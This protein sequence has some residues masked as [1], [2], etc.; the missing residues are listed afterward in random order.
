MKTKIFLLFLALGMGTMQME[1][2]G[3]F[4]QLKKAAKE[5]KQEKK[6][7]EEESLETLLGGESSTSSKKSSQNTSQSPSESSSEDEVT[8][9]VSADGA[10]KD[11]ATKVALRSAIEQAYGTFVSAN[12]TILND[13]LVKDEIVTVTSGNIKHY[14]EIS[15]NVMPDGK[16]FVT[17]QATVCISKL[18]S[19]AQSK[20]AET[21]FAGAT[22]GMNVK[23]KELNKQNEKIAWQNLK[24]QIIEMYKSAFSYQ[25]EVLD[26]KL[27]DDIGRVDFNDMSGYG[28]IS[29]LY[30]PL[31][32][33][34]KLELSGTPND[35]YVTALKINIV[36]NQMMDAIIELIAKTANSLA[37][38][39]D[40]CREY[41][42]MNIP[43]RWYLLD[44]SL[45]S[46]TY[47]ERFRKIIEEENEAD[48]RAYGAGMYYFRTFIPVWEIN[49]EIM[50]ILCN[51]EIVDNMG[52]VSSVDSWKYD[53]LDGNNLGI[54]MEK[55]HNFFAIA[56]RI[57]NSGTGYR[58]T[59][60]Y[61]LGGGINLFVPGTNL[62]PRMLMAIPVLIPKNEISKYSK[63]EVREKASPMIINDPEGVNERRMKEWEQ[64]NK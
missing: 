6:G 35:Y 22:F 49:N 5:I 51:F 58:G 46:D 16:T 34:Q 44:R 32:E 38:T 2:Q 64:R 52:N 40:E 9:V 45:I 28:E 8:L 24:T 25:L 41:E 1:A 26:P 23:M 37:L 12:T 30:F 54:Y 11:E 53:W 47:E 3:L 4:K 60:D 18:V 15:S 10:T 19:Y 33:W 20:G 27:F 62:R 48:Y 61:K 7:Q 31:D 17:L 29:Y 50:K 59:T 43:V 57:A 55:G 13:E 63:F 39:M 36:P 56:A 21:E 42:E 14:S